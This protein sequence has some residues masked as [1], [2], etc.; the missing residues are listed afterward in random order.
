MKSVVYYHLFR[1]KLQMKNF[2]PLVTFSKD[3]NERCRLSTVFLKVPN[4]IGENSD[5]LALGTKTKI[6]LFILF[7]INPFLLSLGLL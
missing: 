3:T 6:V 7:V 4:D 2:S 1:E 5:I